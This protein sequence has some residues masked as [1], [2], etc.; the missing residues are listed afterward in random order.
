MHLTQFHIRSR[1]TLLENLKMEPHPQR[2][3]RASLERTTAD[4]KSDQEMLNTFPP[5]GTQGGKACF[6]DVSTVLEGSAKESRQE[7]Q[8]T[9]KQAGRITE[10]TGL[11]LATRGFQLMLLWD[12][13]APGSS[14]TRI[15]Q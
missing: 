6:H 5:G 9:P 4:A 12:R 15:S 3:Q 1:E 13:A 7:K 14:V 2:G 11:G 10:I 8:Q